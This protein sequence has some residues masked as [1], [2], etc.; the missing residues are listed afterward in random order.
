MGEIGEKGG[1]K[2]RER[3]RKRKRKMGKKNLPK[4]FH[5]KNET[6]VLIGFLHSNKKNTK[7]KGK[8][9]FWSFVLFFF[10]LRKT[11]QG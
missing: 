2:G 8:A 4:K 3:K 1:K 11:K 6:A 7:K 10:L 5:S 9:V